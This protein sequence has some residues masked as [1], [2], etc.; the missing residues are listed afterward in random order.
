MHEALRPLS[1]V[2]P[3]RDPWLI[4]AFS[5]FTDQPGAANL[6][7]KTLVDVWG[8][9]PF[10]DLDPERFY[11]FTVQRPRVRLERGERVLDWPENRI[12][13]ARPEGASRDIL[14]MTGVEPHLRWRTF[15]LAIEDMLRETGCTTSVTLG[16]QGSPVPHTR[17]LPVNLSASHPDFETAFGL[18]AP[19]SRYQGQTGIV[20]VLNLHLRA[21]GW[22]NASLWGMSPH[23][24]NT[25]PNPHVALAQIALLDRALGTT[26]DL[27]DLREQGE[28]FDEQVAEVLRESG[29]DALQYVR[30]LEEQYDNQ[31]P[32]LTSGSSDDA[33]AEL[34]PTGDILDDLEQFLRDQRKGPDAQ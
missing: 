12:F 10:I 17:P 27:T 2:K 21:Q 4:A 32:S 23:Y 11:D 1:E 15:T 8:A 16:A 18:K 9:Q 24:I 6:A 28:R 22:K 25:G 31:R 13:I 29:G 14:L 34:P 19:Q 30:Q 26:T 3:L 33:S 5:G 20:G 7:V